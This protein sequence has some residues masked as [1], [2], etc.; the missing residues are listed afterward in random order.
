MEE[1]GSKK[2]P[3]Y[4]GWYMVAASA[5][6]YMILIG[7][8][9]SAFALF[10]LPVSDEFGLSRADMNTA[11]ICLSIGSSLLAP[12]I[13]RLVDRFPLRRAMIISAI[14]FG[15][16]MS[17]LGL[18][19]SLAFSAFL[20]VIPLPAAL[21][22]TGTI[23]MTVLVA[24]WFTVQRGRAMALSI[25]GM[26]M[27]AFVLAPVIGLL[28][29]GIGWRLALIVSGIVGSS[30]LL[31]LSIAVRDRPGEGDVEGQKGA[32]LPRMEAVAVPAT[33]PPKVGSVLRRM[34]FWLIALS[35]AL[36]TSIM[37]AIGISIVPLALEDGLSMLQATS[38]VSA[39]GGAAIA[40]KLVLSVFADRVDR[41][42]LMTSMF[43]LSAAVNVAL[44]MNTGF[45]PL[46]ACAA[47][48]GVA[49]GALMPVFY[50]LLADRFGTQVFGTVRGLT[51]PIL[52]VMGAVTVRFAGE[53]Y[54][55]TSSYNLLFA[56]FVVAQL[57]AAVLI[58]ST[59]FTRAS[60]GAAN[61]GPSYAG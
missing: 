30:L 4:Y 21:L 3:F 18:S 39:T 24:R 11:L 28:I 37:Q 2:Q 14:V 33:T 25:L 57:L 8:T 35:T 56:V 12:L 9:Y 29:E 20:L 38:L 51:V 41:I 55:R 52:A 47:L 23:T 36:T 16:S 54:D 49:T 32:A 22:G 42:A 15:L 13:G 17:A 6:V 10:V 48:L 26:S 7:S 61:L 5:A 50:A 53:V 58:F 40:G 45:Y 43:V 46:L 34:D 1:P 27:G 19:H 59:R 60:R 31:L 44:L